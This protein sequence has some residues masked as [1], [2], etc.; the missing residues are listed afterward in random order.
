M[1]N[2]YQ[3]WESI[4]VNGHY[5]LVCTHLNILPSYYIWKLWR[6]WCSL[7]LKKFP[8]E[9]AHFQL[10]SRLLFSWKAE[11]SISNILG[12]PRYLT[13]QYLKNKNCLL[14]S[15][16]KEKSQRILTLTSKMYFFFTVKITTAGQLWEPANYNKVSFMGHQDTF[17]KIWP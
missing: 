11:L 16:C 1:I 2:M 17:L 9:T 12:Q 6:C 13:F 15:Q 8:L 4:F 3:K 14:K 7:R 10:R 5:G